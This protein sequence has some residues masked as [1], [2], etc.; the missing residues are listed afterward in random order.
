M[1]L[2]HA[3]GNFALLKCCSGPVPG[4]LCSLPGPSFRCWALCPELGLGGLPADSAFAAG[5]AVA[6]PLWSSLGGCG[7]S[8]GDARP[9][10][11]CLPPGGVSPSAAQALELAHG[12]RGA[13]AAQPVRKDTWSSFREAE[14]TRTRPAGNE[15]DSGASASVGPDTTS[16]TWPFRTLM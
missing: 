7:L 8:S 4:F 11:A 10:R 2:T 13:Q 12:R 3:L 6:E 14:D 16:N 1:T 5:V 15:Q 9:G